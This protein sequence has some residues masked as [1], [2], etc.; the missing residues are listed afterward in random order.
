MLQP[1]L[2]IVRCWPQTLWL[3]TYEYR[4]GKERKGEE[5]RLTHGERLNRNPAL[6]PQ[7]TLYALDRVSVK[8]LGLPHWALGTACFSLDDAR[9]NHKK[10][11]YTSGWIDA[12]KRVEARCLSWANLA[13]KYGLAVADPEEEA[14]GSGTCELKQRW[15]KRVDLI[16]IDAEGLDLDIVEEIIAWHVKHQLERERWPSRIRFETWER[17]TQGARYGNVMA[18]LAKHGYLCKGDQGDEDCLLQM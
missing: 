2:D 9:T 5:R 3:H 10:R 18:M 11:N 6:P 15:R 13:S 4:K 17:K 16:K 8:R 1:E 12:L 14:T 7:L